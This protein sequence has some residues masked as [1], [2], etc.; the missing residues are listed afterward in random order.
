[1]S[2]RT[3]QTKEG[4][5]IIIDGFESGISSSP[6]TGIANI[7]NLNTYYYPKVA[8]VNYKRQ[9]A[10]TNTGVVISLQEHI[11]QMYQ[12]MSAGYSARRRYSL[13]Q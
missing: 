3:E 11:R 1:M 2:T 10:T 8:Y 7:R 6:Y 5:D 4:M 9:P 13:I 12:T